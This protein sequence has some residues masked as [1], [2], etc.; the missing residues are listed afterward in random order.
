MPICLF[1]WCP[2]VADVL[3]VYIWMQRW[4]RN[5]QRSNTYQLQDS[6][7]WWCYWFLL[8]KVTDRILLWGTPSSWFW[9]FDLVELIRT[10]NFQFERKALIK[11]G[12]LPFSP[13]LSRSFMIPHIQLVSYAF[14]WWKN[15]ATR[16]C[17]CIIAS[18]MEVSN[19]TTWSIVDLWL[20]KPHWKLVKNYWFPMKQ[21][22]LLLSIFPWFTQAAC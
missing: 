21:S 19:L 7:N 12:S 6:G 22:S 10:R 14:S 1:C 18:R 17:F 5:H 8:K 13:M 2:V 15:I 3:Y 9:M 16:C 4:C 20:L 11:F